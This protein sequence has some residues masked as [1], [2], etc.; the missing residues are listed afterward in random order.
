MPYLYSMYTFNISS[1]RCL[2]VLFS[3]SL[4]DFFDMFHRSKK[5]R[6]IHPRKFFFNRR[7]L[8]RVSLINNARFI[9]SDNRILKIYSS[10]TFIICLS[11]LYSHM[12]HNF[13]LAIFIKLFF[14]LNETFLFDR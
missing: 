4:E 11:C 7:V 6:P 13:D 5:C 1:I 3:V 9:S 12:K 8:N 10:L 2:T 14:D